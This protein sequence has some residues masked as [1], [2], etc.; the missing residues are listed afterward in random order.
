MTTILIVDDEREIV[1]LV[2]I[3]L[4]REGFSTIKAANGNEALT[5]IDEVW[6]DLAIVDVMM[7]NMDGFTLTKKLRQYD[8]PVLLLTAKGSIEDKESGFQAGSDDYVVKPFEPKELIYRVRA[9][10][11]RYNKD[12]TPLIQVGSLRIDRERYEVRI[13]DVTYMLPLKEFELLTTLATRPGR[14]FERDFLM[15]RVWGLDFS[16]DDQTLN[17]HIKRLREKLHAATNEVK[18]MTVRGVG[19][20][21]EV[22]KP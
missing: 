1:D 10:L 11:R 18:I 12:T 14:V 5:L 4:T 3:H 2:S 22:R 20:K 19:Y 6:P 13:D 8:I 9:I 7:P 21:L 17:V 16:G 15:E